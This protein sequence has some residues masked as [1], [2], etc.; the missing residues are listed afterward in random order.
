MAAKPDV[1]A[2]VTKEV[3]YSL[4]WINVNESMFNGNKRIDD[5]IT[6]NTKIQHSNTLITSFSTGIVQKKCNICRKLRRK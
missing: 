5:T 2:D 1:I 3:N 4:C 6:V